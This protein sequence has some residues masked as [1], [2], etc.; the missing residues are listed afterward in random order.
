MVQA[1]YEWFGDV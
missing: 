1:I